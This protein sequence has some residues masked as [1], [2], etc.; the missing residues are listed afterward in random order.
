MKLC[1]RPGKSNVVADALSRLNAVLIVTGHHLGSIVKKEVKRE[2]LFK[3][4]E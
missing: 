3:G 1:I 2:D 4:L